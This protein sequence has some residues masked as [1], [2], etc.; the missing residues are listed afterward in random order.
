MKKTLKNVAILA[1]MLM[2]VC[3]YIAPTRVKAEGDGNLSFDF[4][5]QHSFTSI[6]EK[7]TYSSVGMKCDSAENS[8][9]YY[10]ARVFG[11]D[12][13]KEK[14]DYSHGYEYIFQEGTYHDMLNWVRENDCHKACVRGE[15][16]GIDSEYGTLFSGVWYPDL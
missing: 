6:E 8:N 11:V 9:A 14:F 12:N 3:A 5:G 16:Y 15:G 1:A 2:I 7:N 13:N 10:Y 4:D